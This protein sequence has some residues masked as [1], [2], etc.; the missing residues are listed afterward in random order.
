MNANCQVPV[1]GRRA[2][3]A[4]TGSEALRKSRLSGEVKV[5]G[6][7]SGGEQ[8]CKARGRVSSR[9]RSPSGWGTEGGGGGLRKWVPERLLALGSLLLYEEHPNLLLAHAAS[10]KWR[11]GQ[12]SVAWISGS[13][14]SPS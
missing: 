6:R 3:G 12:Y 9:D 11:L 14:S 10:A 4:L 2:D 1:L 5:G 8:L 7:E 13:S